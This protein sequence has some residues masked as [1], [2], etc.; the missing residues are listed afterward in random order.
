VSVEVL[1]RRELNRATL[2]RQLL[3]RRSAMPVLEAVEHLVG[4][5]AQLPLNPYTALWSRLERFRPDTLAELLVDRRVVRIVVMRATIHL[6]SAD[7]CLLL[8]PLM[9]PVPGVAARSSRRPR[10]SASTPKSSKKCSGA[11]VSRSL[12]PARAA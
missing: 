4:L 3:L 6:V 1:S 10:T 5:Q 11:T 7:D 9:Q 8:R 12:R 2:E